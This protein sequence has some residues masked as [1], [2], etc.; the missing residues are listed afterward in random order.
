[1]LTETKEITMDKIG[2]VEVDEIARPAPKI[3][4][5]A[6]IK[7]SAQSSCYSDG[8]SYNDHSGDD[9]HNRDSG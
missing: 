2:L 1:M 9:S 7:A 5:A 3:I 8:P 6:K 4:K